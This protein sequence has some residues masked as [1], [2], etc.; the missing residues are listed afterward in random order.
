MIEHIKDVRNI[1]S[2]DRTYVVLQGIISIRYACPILYNS[3]YL[4][5]P[6]GSLV[7][8]AEVVSPWAQ[9]INPSSTSSWTPDEAI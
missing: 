9:P 6:F 3:P 5:V 7:T 1:I 2:N 8:G 4:Y